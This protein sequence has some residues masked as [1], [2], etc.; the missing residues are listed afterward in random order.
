MK[1]TS[2]ALCFAAWMFSALATAAF[3][4]PKAGE[5][6]TKENWEEAKELLPPSV[7]EWVKKGY[8]ILPVVETQLN[9]KG[10]SKFERASRENAGKYALDADGVLIE[11]ASGKISEFVY[12]L[13][14]PDIDP[15][16][17]QAGCK[18]MWNFFIA[19]MVSNSQQYWFDT[20]WVGQ[21]GYERRIECLW[22]RLFFTGRSLGPIPNPDRCYFKDLI[23]VTSPYD[24]A[25]VATLLWRVFGLETDQFWSYA[26]ALRRVRKLPPANAS[27]AFLGSDFCN[28]DAYLFRGK[29]QTFDWKL[30]GQGQV[31]ACLG[32]VNLQPLERDDK[33]QGWRIRADYP[34]VVFGYEVPDF[35]GAPWA[36]TNTVYAVRPA[37]ILEGTPK[38]PFYNYGKQIFWMDQEA[39]YPYYKMVHNRSGE[40]WK[41]M[42]QSLVLVHLPG[43]EKEETYPGPGLQMMYDD[44]SGHASCCHPTSP[45]FLTLYASQKL[46]EDDFSMKALMRAGK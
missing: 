41:S 39:F 29:I 13:P 1:K 34:H 25:G 42:V 17:P 19:Q 16:D 8:Y 43:Q 18:I 33:A 21:K 14:F 12:G 6:I 31:L 38:D 30:L 37:Y 22:Y 20:V 40:Y 9:F 36:P 23:G 35:K 45:K 10:G 46:T 4:L 27:D 26:P 7:L 44:R 2:A 15:S 32:A 24:V 28:D 3:A 5:T 11:K